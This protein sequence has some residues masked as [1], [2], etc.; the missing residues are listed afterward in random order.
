M[1]RRGEAREGSRLEV[2]PRLNCPQSEKTHEPRPPLELGPLAPFPFPKR[3]RDRVGPSRKGG[4]GSRGGEAQ[5]SQGLLS[6]SSWPFLKRNKL[7]PDNS[8][9]LDQDSN[10]SKRT[11][12]LFFA[13]KMCWNGYFYS[14]FWNSTKI[15]PKIG[16]QKHDN[17]SHFAEHKLK[18]IFCCNPLL[19]KNWCFF[20]TSLFW[21]IKTLTL[22][23]TQLKIWN[24]KQR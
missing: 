5:R 2:L 18:N 10:R 16:K 22:N 11:F 14:V 1:I 20:L 23:K 9:Y 21:N 24:K 6:G 13:L 3:C 17:F 8:P 19:T 15:W 12:S 4:S 7:G